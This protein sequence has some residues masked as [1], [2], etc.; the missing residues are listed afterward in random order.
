MRDARCG[1]RNHPV[2]LRVPPLLEKEG[3]NFSPP[4]TR[5]GG[6]VGDGAVW[7]I[8]VKVIGVRCGVS[9]VKP[10][11]VCVTTPS[12]IA[13]HPSLKRREEFPPT[14]HEAGWRR[15]R[16]GGVGYRGEGYRCAVWGIVL[17]PA[18]LRNHRVTRRVPPLREKE[19][20]NFLP[21]SHEAG[22]RRRRRGGA[23]YRVKDMEV[24]TIEVR[25]PARRAP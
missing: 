10:L 5:R 23:G 6:A 14:S 25:P 7:G 9:C 16:R 19:G 1:L 22:W 18:R 20:R 11:H 13:C 4:L 21:T 17:P 3:R 2:T 15:R 12:R 24:Q 8:G